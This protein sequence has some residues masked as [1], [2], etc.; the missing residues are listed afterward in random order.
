MNQIHMAVYLQ[1]P[2]ISILNVIKSPCGKEDTITYVK[3]FDVNNVFN[4]FIFY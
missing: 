3:M 1:S 2:P 4:Y